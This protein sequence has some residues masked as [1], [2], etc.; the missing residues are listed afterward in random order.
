[1]LSN[2]KISDIRFK[3]RETTATKVKMRFLISITQPVKMSWV[4]C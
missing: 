1:M 2:E 4:I 3:A